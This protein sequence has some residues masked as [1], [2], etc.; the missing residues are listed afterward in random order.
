MNDPGTS[1][2]RLGVTCAIMAY[3]EEQNLSQAV[4]EVRGHLLKSGRPF[5]VL[6]VDD[7]STDRTAA[8]ADE[9]AA[10]HD[11]VRVIRHGTNRGPG[12]AI[13]TGVAEARLPLY[14]FHPADN[15][16]DFGDICRALT[17]LD[18][19]YDLLVGQR[20]DRR[21]YS[22]MRLLASYTSI[23]LNRVLFHL[24]DYRD[25]NFIYLW[26]TELVKPM[27]PLRTTGV[28]L[29]TEVLIRARD[30]G[31]RIGVAYAAYRPRVAG[32]STVGRPIVMARTLLQVLRF[33][34]FWTAQRHRSG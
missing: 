16:V 34:A 17:L 15:Q 30:A 1:D 21:D 4:A 29:C 28:F 22:P 7:G 33:W 32:K 13:V 31:A 5:E 27:L 2:A 6:I 12:S 11:D 23:A 24:P 26:R 3:N 10:Q 14:C 25:F 19:D 8:I 9:L 18:R 20:S